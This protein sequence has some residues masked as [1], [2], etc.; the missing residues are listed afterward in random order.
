[1]AAWPVAGAAYAALAAFGAGYVLV[2]VATNTFMQ[3][4]GSDEVLARVFGFMESARFAAMAA[5][6]IVAPALAALLGTRWAIVVVGALPALFAALRWGR[7]RGFDSGAE[8]DA[9][10]YALLRENEIFRPL[11]VATLERLCHD[12]VAVD[13]AEGVD[14]I[15]Q[16]TGGDRFY[17]IE[18]G[19]VAV[20]IDGAKCASDRRGGS[21]GEI[22]LLRDVP[23]T[24][25][26]RVTCPSRLLT[27]ER[28]QFVGA[29]TG[30]PR[31]HEV[32]E[33]MIEVRLGNERA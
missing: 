22:A 23:R 3:R 5:G 10:R 31:C 7:L 4:L 28:D 29:V 14:V 13:V 16:G 19:E 12:L 27:L 24:A 9:D 2:E 18:S 21:F 11:P 32:A 25:T 8:V 15:T 20:F 6:G 1:M 30:Y 33:R 26:V 17:L